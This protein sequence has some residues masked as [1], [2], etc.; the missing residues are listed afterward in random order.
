M[1]LVALAVTRWRWCLFVC[2]SKFD[3]IFADMEPQEGFSSRGGDIPLGL[4]WGVEDV[5][6]M[7][8][9]NLICDNSTECNCAVCIYV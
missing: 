5:T 4:F 6:L 1:R 3:I 2:S 9:A 7:I 8:E